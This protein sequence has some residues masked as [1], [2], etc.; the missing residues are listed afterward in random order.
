MKPTYDEILAGWVG[1]SSISMKLRVLIVYALGPARVFYNEQTIAGIVGCTPKTVRK[2]RSQLWKAGLLIPIDGQGN[3]VLAVSP[4]HSGYAIGVLPPSVPHEVVRSGGKRVPWEDSPLLDVFIDDAVFSGKDYKK[5]LQAFEPF[6]W[7]T[8]Y[9]TF[10]R[11]WVLSLKRRA[12]DEN[13]DLTS[14]LGQW[15]ATSIMGILVMEYKAKKPIKNPAALVSKIIKEFD[16]TEMRQTSYG[17]KAGFKEQR[18]RGSK[19]I[20]DQFAE[21]RVSS[22]EVPAKPTVNTKNIPT[23]NEPSQPHVEAAPSQADLMVVL[24]Y[25]CTHKDA[26]FGEIKKDV[27]D[28]LKAETVVV[29]RHLRTLCW[30]LK[31][32][33]KYNLAVPPEAD[34]KVVLGYLQTHR[35]ATF[36]AIKNTIGKQ[37]E[38]ELNGVISYLRAQGHVLKKADDYRLAKP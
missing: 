28:K 17:L 7:P 32:D 2:Y 25:L 26:T 1:C 31:D 8:R 34:R 19:S 21:Q 3:K 10:W 16:G 22:E 15:A 24:K 4:S 37:L 5:V 23:P 9:R 20:R 35:N 14:G 27:A 11:N 29:T 36:E 6:R 18:T 13:L 12:E 33:G 38:S 30:I